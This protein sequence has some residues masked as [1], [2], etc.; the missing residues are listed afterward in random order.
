MTIKPI[1]I[2]VQEDRQGS[3]QK[4]SEE[5]KFKTRKKGNNLKHNLSRFK[6]S[7][8]AKLLK[9]EK[10]MIKPNESFYTSNFDIFVNMTNVAT[11]IEEHDRELTVRK[12]YC[13]W[14]ERMIFSLKYRS[15]VNVYTSD[16]GLLNS[17][18]C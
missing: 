18:S 3:S 11:R 6:H 16:G 5:K 14:K 17:V 7:F 9:R 8:K 10:K 13:H 1:L 15:D 4:L 2:S 12:N